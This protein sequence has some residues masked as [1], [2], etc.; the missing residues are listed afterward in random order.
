MNSKQLLLL[1]F[2]LGKKRNFLIEELAVTVIYLWSATLRVAYGEGV[3]DS[4]DS[5]WSVS[6]LLNGRLI[7]V[8]FRPPRVHTYLIRLTESSPES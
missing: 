2:R 8:T 6:R 3:C 1:V 5:R 4:G 7:T